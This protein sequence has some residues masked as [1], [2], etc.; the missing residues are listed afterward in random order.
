VI[1]VPERYR[2]TDGRTERRADRRHYGSTAICVASRGKNRYRYLYFH[3][4]S[5]FGTSPVAAFSA[6]Q[7]ACL[8]NKIACVVA[9]VRRTV[10]DAAAAAVRQKSNVSCF[11]HSTKKKI[12]R[13]FTYF[14]FFQ[15]PRRSRFSSFVVGRFDDSSRS[16]ADQKTQGWVASSARRRDERRTDPKRLND[17]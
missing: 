9:V 1:T 3:K 8:F 16:L 10:A 15:S 6:H 13:N 17:S 5:V 4:M 7:R 11:Y 12:R 14:A 2:Q